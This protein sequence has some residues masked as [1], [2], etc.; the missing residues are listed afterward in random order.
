[1]RF[2]AVFPVVIRKDFPKTPH[3]SY[4]GT[5]RP[6]IRPQHPAYQMLI[7]WPQIGHYIG[8]SRNYEDPY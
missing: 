3:F 4:F 5:D 8:K 7:F 1:L 6:L 2:F